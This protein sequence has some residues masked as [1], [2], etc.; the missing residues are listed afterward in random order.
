M[1]NGETRNAKEIQPLNATVENRRSSLPAQVSAGRAEAA[2][3]M[4][5]DQAGSTLTSIPQEIL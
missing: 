2:L 1:R 4:V 5:M 3:Q